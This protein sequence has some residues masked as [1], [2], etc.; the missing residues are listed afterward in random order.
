MGDHLKSP[1]WPIW[2]LGSE[3]HLTV[4]FSRQVVKCHQKCKYSCYNVFCFQ[5]SLVA[6]PSPREA[7]VSAFTAL[8]TDQSGFIPS[9]R[10]KRK[11]QQLL[12]DKIAYPSPLQP[13][14]PD[15]EPQPLCWGGIC[16]TDAIKDGLW[17]LGHYLN[18]SGD[19]VKDFLQLEFHLS[20]FLEE[21]YPDSAVTSCPDSFT[22]H[23]YNGLVRGEGAVVYFTFLMSF[24]ADF[25][26]LSCDQMCH[27]FRIWLQ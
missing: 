9:T 21:F 12:L 13:G 6:P 3:T 7:A 26:Q 11:I 4:L 14:Y 22:L 15:A 18:S 19:K 8:D 20:Q 1:S 27:E 5:L 23:H 25:V 10:F 17:R 24:L 2:V 16:W